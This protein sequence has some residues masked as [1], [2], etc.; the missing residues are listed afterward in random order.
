MPSEHPTDVLDELLEPRGEYIKVVLL[1]DVG[2]AYDVLF[3]DAHEVRGE[4][5]EP[6]LHRPS[7]DAAAPAAAPMAV[8]V[9]VLVLVVMVVLV[10]LAQ[11]EGGGEGGLGG[12]AWGKDSSKGQVAAAGW[13]HTGGDLHTAGTEQGHPR[14]A[15]LNPNLVN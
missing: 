1:Q 10:V 7:H 13:E 15:P 9:L 14:L 11:E 8:V 6:A 3:N 5:L 2:Q 12:G 4:L